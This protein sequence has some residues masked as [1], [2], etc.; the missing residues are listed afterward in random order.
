MSQS[1]IVRHA[2]QLAVLVL[3]GSLSVCVYAHG[4]AG[5]RFFPATLTIDDPFVANEADLL[6]KHI[7]APGDGGD[8]INTTTYSLE[9]AKAI[10]PRFGLSVATTYDHLDAGT[11][12]ITQ[13]LENA[14][15]GTRYIAYLNDAHETLIAT[16][17]NIEIGNSGNHSVAETASTFSPY[18]LFGKGLG[19]ASARYLRPLAI[20][21]VIEPNISSRRSNHPDTL[22]WG[23]TVQYSLPYLQSF[24]KDIGLPRPFNHMI[25][26]IEFPMNTCL[27]QS[28]S[29]ETTGY[30]NP[31]VIWFGRYGQIGLEAQIPINQRTGTHTG[32]LLQ[33]HAYLDD[34]FPH[35][36]GRPTFH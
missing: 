20:T 11:S 13:G 2:I 6:I 19:D 22:N 30:A 33:F 29:G 15:L 3:F 12:G 7:K 35:G 32:I 16:G 5:K 34:L 36:L 25:P 8:Q 4:F 18:V 21:G 24:V 10:T 9:F 26:L 23:F 27:N 1:Y 31:G 17:L 28:C 14:E